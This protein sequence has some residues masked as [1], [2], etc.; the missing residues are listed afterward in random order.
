MNQQLIGEGNP[1]SGDER[2]QRRGQLRPKA[3]MI[4]AGDEFDNINTENSKK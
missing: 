3:R 1:R 4:L 2:N